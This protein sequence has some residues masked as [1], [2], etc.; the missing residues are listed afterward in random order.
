MLRPTSLT[1][2]LL[3]LWFAATV[4]VLFCSG[5]L[6]LNLQQR[7][8]QL[9]LEQRPG[10]DVHTDCCGHRQR[11]RQHRFRGRHHDRRSSQR[12]ADRYPDQP[13]HR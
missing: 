3:L 8:A 5:L 7:Q 1:H 12:A 2:R 6:Y 13:G 4:G 9:E 10:R 11:R